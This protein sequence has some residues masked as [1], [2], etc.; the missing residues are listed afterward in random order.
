M[1]LS[2]S[3]PVA[4]RATTPR[5]GAPA[6]DSRAHLLSTVLIPL[7]LGAGCGGS[8]SAPVDAGV[9]PVVE[10]ASTT[11]IDSRADGDGG[12]LRDAGE[13]SSSLCGDEC[14]DTMVD[15]SHC[16]ACDAPCEDPAGGTA[17]CEAG[18]CVLR[19]D[20]RHV[21]RDGSC[22][23]R[24][25]RPSV[26][27]DGDGLGDLVVGSHG[28]VSVF[29]ATPTPGGSVEPDQTLESPDFSSNFGRQVAALGDVDGDGIGDLAVL[30]GRAIYVYRGTIG[31]IDGS[32]PAELRTCP[33]DDF[34]CTEDHI[35]PAGDVDGDG[36]A[37]LLVTRSPYS[38]FLLRGTGGGLDASPSHSW[39]GR[40]LG[41]GDV[42]GDGDSDLLKW[43]F[44]QELG[45][46]ESDAGSYTET[47]LV[48]PADFRVRQALGNLDVNGDG[49]A[50]VAALDT[51]WGGPRVVWW[52]GSPD[53]LVVEPQG[54]LAL[55]G[56][57]SSWEKDSL[58]R[59][60]FD[61]DGFGDL[62]VARDLDTSLAEPVRITVFFGA[63]DG[64]DAARRTQ[65]ERS[66]DRAVPIIGV[67]DIDGDGF[68]D[69]AVGAEGLGP[70][71][72]LRGG[73][74]ESIPTLGPRF[75][76]DG[77]RPGIALGR[78]I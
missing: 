47:P 8:R 53:G 65:V 21:A 60:D 23:P 58:A 20:V 40:V 18:T 41:A 26:D 63:T 59:G 6:R 15:P 5:T 46:V 44:T 78:G 22:T 11:P 17:S 3:A 24:P 68:D 76:A 16:G 31:G 75:A 49:Y 42:D 19:C 66:A 72:L 27:V 35:A 62:A 30:D 36:L 37:D 50:D 43:E 38:T 64:L 48:L 54:L 52:A 71:E 14:V 55:S 32:R 29:T 4:N 10:D 73:P 67:G 51:G 74:R 61:G 70:I 25:P 39:T 9:D 77:R 69:F 28:I 56:D 1:P 2:L 13:C 33:R 57:G 12:D 45:W 7:L 34:R